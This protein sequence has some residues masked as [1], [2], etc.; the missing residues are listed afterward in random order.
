MRTR[1]PGTTSDSPPRDPIPETGGD[2][3]PAEP[4]ATKSSWREGKYLGFIS[5]A[6]VLLMW[7]AVTKD[8]F[9]LVRPIKF[10]SPRMVVEGAGVVSHVLAKDIAATLAR[11]FVGW[12]AGLLVG[13]GFGLWISFNKTANYFFHP[14]SVIEF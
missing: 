9:D 6:L 7:F 3:F 12:A 1:K 11:V 2:P 8:G 5:V 14:R 13:V 10:P 4:T